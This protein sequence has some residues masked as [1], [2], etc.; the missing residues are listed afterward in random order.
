MIVLSLVE[1]GWQTAR[2]WSLRECPPRTRVVHVI[3]GTIQPEIRA[4]IR[5]VAGVEVMAVPRRAFWPL[6]FSLFLWQ[7]CRGR[8]QTVLVDNLR[9]HRRVGRWIRWLHRPNVRMQLCE[10]P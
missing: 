3:K 6:I 2:E 4:L 1:R 7:A 10:S 5:P 9:S 8:L